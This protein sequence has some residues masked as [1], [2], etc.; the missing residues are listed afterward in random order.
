[1]GASIISLPVH[2]REVYVWRAWFVN[3]LLH[4]AAC[5]SWL[6]RM[7]HLTRNFPPPRGGTAPISAYLYLL[8][9]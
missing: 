8:P 2:A 9:L 6:W 7:H 3:S 5:S 1:L 4:G